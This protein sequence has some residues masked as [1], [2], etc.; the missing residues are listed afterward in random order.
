MDFQ[1]HAIISEEIHLKSEPLDETETSELETKNANEQFEED[2]TFVSNEVLAVQKD[3]LLEMNEK[4]IKSLFR[5]DNTND[6]EFKK[7]AENLKK[8]E[9]NLVKSESEHPL[10]MKPIKTIVDEGVNLSDHDYSLMQF[11]NRI[12]CK[13]AAKKI[14]WFKSKKSL[15]E[16][17]KTRDKFVH[18]NKKME[19]SPPS[20][21]ALNASKSRQSN[22]TYCCVVDCSK[23]V[24]HDNSKF[25]FTNQLAIFSKQT[26]AAF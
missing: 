20:F 24:V 5:P 3:N 21:Q 8:L 15:K 23:N 11:A 13:T 2:K 6:D 1:D 25:I 22:G 9:E 7:N 19:Q 12:S 4:V 18:G 10:N 17:I 14:D 26:W 16:L